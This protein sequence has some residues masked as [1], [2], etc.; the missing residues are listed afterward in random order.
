MVSIQVGLFPRRQ[1][2]LSD[3]M[4]DRSPIPTD[5][6]ATLQ[7]VLNSRSQAQSQNSSW[8]QVFRPYAFWIVGLAI[9]VFLS[10]YGYKLSLYHCHAESSSHIAVAKLWIEPRGASVAALSSLKAN[11][12]FASE[13][14][15]ISPT[16]QRPPSLCRDVAFILHLCEHHAVFFDLL[17]PSRAPP[18][19]RFRLV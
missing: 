15:A 17:V 6:D 19:L 5:A 12:H 1:K 9:A 14:Q 4:S 10:G 16:I 7:C 3:Q 18:P 8:R 13:S 2:E 11:S